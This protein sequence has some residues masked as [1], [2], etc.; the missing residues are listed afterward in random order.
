MYGGKDAVYEADDNDLFELTP[1]DVTSQSG[2]HNILTPV[3]SSENPSSGTYKDQYAQTIDSLI[4]IGYN[5]VTAQEACQHDIYGGFT[6]SDIKGKA[7]VF[8]C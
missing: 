7:T 2:A 8:L 3:K 1:V 6:N 4:E 5:E